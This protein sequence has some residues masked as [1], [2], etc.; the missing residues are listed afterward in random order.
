VTLGRKNG[1]VNKS[2][3]KLGEEE[4]KCFHTTVAK[5]LYLPKWSWTDI[6]LVV[7]FLY[8]RV[9]DLLLRTR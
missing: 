7:G 2:A 1:F 3:E 6:I 9:R 4:Q 5:L 8:T